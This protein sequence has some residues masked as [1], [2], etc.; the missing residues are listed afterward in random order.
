MPDLEN[1]KPKLRLHSLHKSFTVGGELEPVLA[2]VDLAVERGEFVSIIGPS[3]C[4][5]ST[6]LNIIA[7]LDHPDSGS[8]S[9]D[10]GDGGEDQQRLGLVLGRAGRRIHARSG[11]GVS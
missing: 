2:G 3:G 1:P 5:K 8:V 11:Q 7:G 10:G 9:L 4:G 6:L